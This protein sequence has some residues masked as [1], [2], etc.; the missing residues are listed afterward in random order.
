MSEDGH[1]AFAGYH[2]R[3]FGEL[4]ASAIEENHDEIAGLKFV[5]TG[6]VWADE[7]YEKYGSWQTVLEKALSTNAGMDACL[8]FYDENYDSYDIMDR[9]AAAE[10]ENEDAG[11]EAEAEDTE[12]PEAGSEKTYTV[13]KGDCLWTIA[14]MH[15]GD[16]MRWKEI[17]ELNKG[18]IHDPGLIYPGQELVL[19]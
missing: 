14:E 1:L 9:V 10:E 2:A 15:L 19:P 6:D 17:Y 4:L 12:T 16:G 8:G 18:I 7:L 3:N 13:Q 5:K 11:S